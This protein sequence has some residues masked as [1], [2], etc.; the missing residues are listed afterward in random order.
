MGFL[1]KKSDRVVLLVGLFFACIAL[2]QPFLK[3]FFSSRSPDSSLT[4]VNRRPVELKEVEVKLPEFVDSEG[5]IDLNS[6]DEEELTRLP[7]IG[8][9]LAERIVS[10]R[11]NY[12]NLT[13]LAG[14]KE[15]DGIGPSTL[16][17]IRDRLKL[18]SESS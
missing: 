9:V 8:P 13:S 6:A 17:R 11:S 16:E 18:N 15:V 10:Y 1:L 14:L 5:K 7:G 2:S 12:G 3:G 4:K